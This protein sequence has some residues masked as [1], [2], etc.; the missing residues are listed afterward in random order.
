MST[1]SEQ[2]G[3][4]TS[5]AT[6]LPERPAAPV[7]QLAAELVLEF[8]ERTDAAALEL[9]AQLR[10]DYPD[11]YEWKAERAMRQWCFEQIRMGRT[12][13]R[14]QIASNVKGRETVAIQ[15]LD[16]LSLAALVGWY[17]WPLVTGIKLGDAT[18]SEI[19]ESVSK[20]EV[21]ASTY[22]RRSE[23]LRL[24]QSRL[25]SA[26]TRVRDALTDEE[27]RHLAVQSGITAEVSN[28]RA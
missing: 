10:R 16:G 1:T 25:P 3:I 12:T 27:L 14:R 28:G 13:L 7:A 21:D 18:T 23:F 2:V 17:D 8:G 5:S 11:F 20:Y 4:S 22:L 6:P 26:D 24:V 15:G 9:H 19:E